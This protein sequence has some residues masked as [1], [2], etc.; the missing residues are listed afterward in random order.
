MR[1]P[2]YTLETQ[3]CK[4]ACV[5]NKTKFL[6]GILITILGAII[7]L[8]SM[9]S[10]IAL[11]AEAIYEDIYAFPARLS[12]STD[13]LETDSFSVKAGNNFSLWLK[14][15]NR[16]IENKDFTFSA[17]LV[18]QNGRTIADFGEDFRFGYLRNSYG[19]GQYYKL[20][21]HNFRD[22]FIGYL[23][24]ATSGK[25]I[26]PYDGFLVIRKS[27]PLTLPLK[28]IGIF[29]TGIFILITGIGTIAKNKKS[30]IQSN[31]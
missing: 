28:Q 16:K 25:W 5:M 27:N 20:G 6:L 22:D 30:V 4:S 2:S 24:Y 18:E 10:G 12:I 1:L 14:V 7:M 26:P 31:T 13:N 3:F 8:V 9:V 15:P 23:S 19:R 29:V 11:F 17:N 21:S